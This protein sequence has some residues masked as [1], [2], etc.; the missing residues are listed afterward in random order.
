MNSARRLEL[1]SECPRSR[2][3]LPCAGPERFAGTTGERVH[4]WQP[5]GTQGSSDSGQR[6]AP[7]KAAL[8]A[9]TARAA[10]PLPAG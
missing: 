6:A 1:P 9:N 4:A 2:L 8:A 5:R 3:V 7:M 10:C